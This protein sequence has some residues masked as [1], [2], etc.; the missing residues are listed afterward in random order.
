M[1]RSEANAW[2]VSETALNGLVC[3]DLGLDGKFL[4]WDMRVDCDSATNLPYRV[5][6]LAMSILWILGY[7][8]LL[9]GLLYHYNVPKI[10]AR[11]LLR[12]KVGA[13]LAY[14]L[15][16]ERINHVHDANQTGNRARPLAVSA[17]I[18]WLLGCICRVEVLPLRRSSIQTNLRR[19]STAAEAQLSLGGP[20]S[21]DELGV[22]KLHYLAAVHQ[23]EHAATLGKAELL[24]ALYTGMDALITSGR[25]AVPA[26]FWDLG[27]PDA[28]ERLACE[29][30]G[31]LI[32][33]YKVFLWW[34]A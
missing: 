7:P 32:T 6:A 21:L 22:D 17:S 15:H 26:A 19:R 28:D 5:Y 13:F 12:A 31:Q 3:T 14:S 29:H 25:I 33:A 1:K 2:Q 24:K 4:K 8:L 20:E 27:S 16:L 10:A 11:K 34:Y 30:L 9:L 23:V 18:Y